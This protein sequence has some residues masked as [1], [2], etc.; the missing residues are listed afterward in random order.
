MILKSRKRV[1]RGLL[2][3]FE[4]GV[5]V[6]QGSV[7]SPLQIILIMEEATKSCAVCGP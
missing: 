7:L 5:G 3:V 6:Y 1:A 4:I 2:D